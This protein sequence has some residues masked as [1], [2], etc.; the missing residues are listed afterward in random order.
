M[1]LVAGEY[2]GGR[3]ICLSINLYCLILSIFSHNQ[4]IYKHFFMLSH[5]ESVVPNFFADYRSYDK[6]RNFSLFSYSRNFEKPSS[7][8]NISKILFIIFIL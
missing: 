3:Y 7:M 6:N 1:S 4:I 2:N 8:T 5:G